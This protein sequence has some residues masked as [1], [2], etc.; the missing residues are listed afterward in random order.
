[1]APLPAFA[2]DGESSEI[3]DEFVGV[4]SVVLKS[5]HPPANTAAAA[6]SST[7]QRRTIRN[8]SFQVRALARV[9]QAFA[10]IKNKIKNRPDQE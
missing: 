1:M 8:R 9:R 7:I 6:P 5:L 3:V 4:P 2:P 10:Q